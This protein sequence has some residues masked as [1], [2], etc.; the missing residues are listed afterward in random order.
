MLEKKECDLFVSGRLCL[1]GEHSDWAGKYRTLNSAI[2]PGEA[3][4]TG[5]EEGISA[6]VK[7]HNKIVINSSIDNS[8]F[9]CDLDNEILSKIAISGG[10]YSYI[11]GVVLYMIENYNVNGLEIEIYR[12][13]LPI[14]KGL[15]SSAAICVLTA[16]AFNI[17][18]DLQLTVIEEMQIAYL[19]ESMTPSKCGKLDQ[20]CAFGINPVDIVFDGEEVNI[21]SLKVGG[22]FHWVF[23]DLNGYKNTIKILSDLHMCYPF[24]ETDIEKNVQLALGKINKEIINE[25]KVY[26]ELGDCESLG[27][28]MNY[29]QDI[30]DKFIC[31]ASPIELK[32]PILHNL[33]T[34]KKINELVYG[35]K[36]VGSHGD[37]CI[38]FLAKDS[39]SQIK[40]IEYLEQKLNMKSYKLTL[41]N[42][43]VVKNNRP[44]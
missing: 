41:S 37:G 40:L 32:S 6:K 25:A 36:G 34:D 17:I 30:F 24:A 38:Q 7:K 44:V 21:K 4:V 33:I 5:I 12:Q 11:C 31:P 43:N 27:K 42:S 3:I 16:K 9:E 15:S 26:L 13:T 39:L 8:H 23:A 19:G 20:A 1:F 10:Y 2:L 14:K 29:S 35:A 22:D 18:Y 28:L